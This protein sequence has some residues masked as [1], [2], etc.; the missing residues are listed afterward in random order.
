MDKTE[1]IMKGNFQVQEAVP[2]DNSISSRERLSLTASC[3]LFSTHSIAVSI[4]NA[5][6]E[7]NIEKKPLLAQKS[8]L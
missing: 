8:W 4:V 7:Q 3:E 5:A 1:T 6:N 2:T